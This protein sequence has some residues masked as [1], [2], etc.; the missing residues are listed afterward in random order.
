MQNKSEVKIIMLGCLK[1]GL[2][3][4]RQEVFALNGTGDV[5]VA[6]KRNQ[7]FAFIHKQTK[8]QSMNRNLVFEWVI[9]LL[10]FYFSLLFCFY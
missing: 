1:G 7:S 3:E 8:R 6:L 9:L 10:L 2:R 5:M 4:R